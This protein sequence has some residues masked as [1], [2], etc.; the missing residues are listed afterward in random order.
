MPQSVWLWLS[1][2]LS[3]TLPLSFLT[4]LLLFIDLFHHIL[5]SP[6][7]HSLTG[8]FPP[9]LFSPASHTTFLSFSFWPTQHCNLESSS[10]SCQPWTE[11]PWPA[12]TQRPA[13]ALPQRPALTQRQ[14]CANGCGPDHVPEPAPRPQDYKGETSL[15]LYCFFLTQP[16]L[17]TITVR[18]DPRRPSISLNIEKHWKTLK[19][20][21]YKNK[22]FPMIF[23]V[24][25]W[26]YESPLSSLP[27][28][29][30]SSQKRCISKCS[31][32]ELRHLLSSF[33]EING[34]SDAKGIVVQIRFMLLLEYHY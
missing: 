32:S 12:Q 29:P 9:F 5:F 27:R 33:E 23:N 11:K 20:I 19:K 34:V 8:V 30:L 18:W 16:S 17:I 31:F 4:C 15:F 21:I 24:S 7:L 22:C 25:Q 2:S 3:G 26:A 13:L 14:V 10:S 6:F 1:L 28:A